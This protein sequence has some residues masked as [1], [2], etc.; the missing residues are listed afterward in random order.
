MMPDAAR[1]L[2]ALVLQNLSVRPP[3]QAKGHCDFPGFFEDLRI[4]GG[5]LIHQCRGIGACVS[6]YDVQRSSRISCLSV[7]ACASAAS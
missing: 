5:G 4:F 2:N 7:S 6:L 1:I 3:P